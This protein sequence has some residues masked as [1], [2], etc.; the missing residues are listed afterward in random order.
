VVNYTINATPLERLQQHPL[1]LFTTNHTDCKFFV[2][3][4][5]DCN[6]FKTITFIKFAIIRPSTLKHDKNLWN[7]RGAPDET[8]CLTAFLRCPIA[9]ALIC[10]KLFN[11]CANKL[12]LFLCEGWSRHDLHILVTASFCCDW[13]SWVAYAQSFAP[14]Q[15]ATIEIMRHNLLYYCLIAPHIYIFVLCLHSVLGESHNQRN[16]TG[17]V[18]TAETVFKCAAY[19][20]K[21]LW[22]LAFS[23]SDVA[24]WVWENCSWSFHVEDCSCSCLLPCSH[25]STLSARLDRSQVLFYHVCSITWP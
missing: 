10:M 16:T 1:L 24:V 12:S 18:A 8:T 15:Q 14:R 11:V 6:L 22:A 19:L 7:C 17:E 21:R 9:L 23:L 13:K 5:A 3:H 20:V 4:P 25:L 2:D